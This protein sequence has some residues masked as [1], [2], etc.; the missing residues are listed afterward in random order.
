[1]EARPL[2]AEMELFRDSA[3]RF[4]QREIRPHRE[5]WRD[6]NIV[7]REAFLKAG[8]AGFLCIWADEQYGGLGLK[9]F[10]YEQILIEAN[11]FH[12][13]PGYF[14][15]LHSRLV[16]PYIQ[17]F[18]T[19]EQKQ[20]F[21]PGMISGETILAIAMTEPDAGSD[22]AGMKSRAV[23]QGDHWVLNGSKTYISNGINA[24]LV[25]VAART[26]A[27][28]PHGITLFLVERGMEGFERGRNL[29]KMGL[30][31]QDTAELFFRDVRI[32]KSN[33]LGEVDRGFYHLM[34]GLAEERL[35]AAVG[36]VAAARL[37]LDIT[38]DFVKQRLV[39]GKPLS[40]MQNTRFKLAALDAEIEMAQVYVDRCVDVHNE[41]KLSAVD[42]ARAKL[43]T[44]ELNGRMVDEGVQLHGGAGYMEEYEICRLYQ[45]ERIHRILA[46]T[47]EIMK[48][49]I[50]RAI[51]D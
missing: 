2:S 22:L 31:S 42:A 21:L 33:V 27:D 34:Q 10:R 37:A 4:F 15:T 50:A 6:A 13:D 32:P 38:K 51:L 5:R 14:I 18:G 44:S 41:G 48:E 39:F 1:M 24:D 35:I 40:K 17:H 11:T 12:G 43:F 49:I 19:D 7:D 46:G 16:G 28:N 47:S 25:I 3:C 29:K 20:R 23:E 8:N 36:N 9:D 45:D 30:K 26:H